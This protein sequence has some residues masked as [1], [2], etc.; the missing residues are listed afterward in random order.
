VVVGGVRI[1]AGALRRSEQAQSYE[2]IAP[3]TKRSGNK[4]W[5][6]FRSVCPKFSRQSFHELQQRERGTQHHAAA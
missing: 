1:A 3:V 2:G 5:V 6:H 4:K